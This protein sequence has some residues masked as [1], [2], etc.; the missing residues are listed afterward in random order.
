MTV[1]VTHFSLFCCLTEL[2][3]INFKVDVTAA[4]STAMPFFPYREIPIDHYA[5]RGSGG[6]IIIK[7]SI[8]S[9]FS[10]ADYLHPTDL[11]L[12]VCLCHINGSNSW[13]LS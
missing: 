13:P 5:C 7:F 12:S 8:D 6:M 11:N 4:N 3:N 10:L 1:C 9:T 2:L